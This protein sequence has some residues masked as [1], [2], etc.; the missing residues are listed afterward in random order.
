MADPFCGYVLLRLSNRPKYMSVCKDLRLE[1]VQRH[2]EAR[3]ISVHTAGKT[4]IV[5]KT[6][7]DLCRDI[8]DSYASGLKTIVFDLELSLQKR[9]IMGALKYAQYRKKGVLMI[10]EK[11]RVPETMDTKFMTSEQRMVYTVIS[12]LK[13]LSATRKRRD[14]IAYLAKKSGI[15]AEM[16]AGKPPKKKLVVGIK[17]RR[18]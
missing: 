5:K 10:R 17:R 11:H 12:V 18:E 1:E 3:G 13:E 9:V 6:K 7:D 2:A 4:K 8:L 15:P 16:P 14:P